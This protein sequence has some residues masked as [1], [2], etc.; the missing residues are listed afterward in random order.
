VSRH[1]RWSSAYY[2]SGRSSGGKSAEGGLDPRIRELSHLIRDIPPRQP[3]QRIICAE[4]L[5]VPMAK[6]QFWRYQPVEGKEGLYCQGCRK[7][8][9]G[10]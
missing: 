3:S 8:Q 10:V 2:P 7:T 4:C 1:F 5:R 6:N 9:D